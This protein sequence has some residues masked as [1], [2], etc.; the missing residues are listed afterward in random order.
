MHICVYIY[1]IYIYYIYI[2]II[3]I[4]YIY[5][6]YIRIQ[7]SLI[8]VSPISFSYAFLPPTK[9]FCPRFPYYSQSLC[10]YVCVCAT[11]FNLRDLHEHGTGYLLR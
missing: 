6:I 7:C 11:I 2:Y 9:P 3:Y 5:I 1:I 10:V 8:K 4:Y